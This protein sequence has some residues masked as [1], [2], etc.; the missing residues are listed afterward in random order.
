MLCD[1]WHQ[2]YLEMLVYELL[3]LHSPNHLDKF[4][5]IVAKYIWCKVGHH[6]GDFQYLFPFPFLAVFK[7]QLLPCLLMLPPR[8]VRW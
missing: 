8:H 5:V 3:H 1:L 4:F 7:S 6:S 2:K